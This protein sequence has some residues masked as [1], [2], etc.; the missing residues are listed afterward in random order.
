MQS[1]RQTF[2]YHPNIG[3]LYVPGLKMRVPH[4]NGG[5]LVQANQA[6]FRSD[7][8]FEARKANGSFRALVFGDSITAGQ[9]ISNKERYSDLLQTLIPDVEV[10]NLGLDGTGTDQQY[11]IFQ[12]FAPRYEHDLVIIGIYIENIRRVVA[13]YRLFRKRQYI[14]MMGINSD[15]RPIFA[16]PYFTLGSNDELVRHH[17]PVPREPL[18]EADLPPNEREAVDR[19]GPLQM[20]RE[21][22]TNLGL[23]DMVQKLTHYQPFPAY[24][25]PNSEGWRMLRA[26]L[27]HWIRESSTPVVICPVPAYQHVEE[28][29]DPSS[30]QQRFREL[31][32]ETG[33]IFHDPLPDFLRLSMSERR[34]FR[35]KT[36]LHPAAGFHRVLAESL[37]PC[38][39]PLV[40]ERVKTCP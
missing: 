34:N 1:Y 37:V 12:E 19:G 30:Y 11:V 33:A 27:V 23:K 3:H 26:I 40:R 16:K 18:D 8:E 5:Y 25:D 14:E 31:C 21:G 15:A 7:R 32:A 28:T 36:D 4:E 20:I 13:H 39:Q 2:Q 35:Y 29:T 10:Y 6:G 9:P 24:D 38:V 17:F 22:L